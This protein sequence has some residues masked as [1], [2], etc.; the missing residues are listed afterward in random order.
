[1]LQISW[2]QLLQWLQRRNKTTL[3]SLAPAGRPY[4]SNKTGILLGCFHP[5]VL[6]AGQGLVFFCYATAGPL[7]AAGRA[8]LPFRVL[9]SHFSS[10]LLSSLP[11]Q[12]APKLLPL[13]RRS[14]SPAASHWL[15]P[16][17][18]G[19]SWEL[20]SRS[21]HLIQTKHLQ[22]NAS[23][24]RKPG[25]RNRVG[26]LGH[27]LANFSLVFCPNRY[28]V[29]RRSRATQ[30]RK[31]GREIQLWAVGILPLDVGEAVSHLCYK[32]GQAA[33]QTQS[34]Q[35][36][37]GTFHTPT[38]N[39]MCLIFHPS[40]PLFFTGWTSHTDTGGILVTSADHQTLPLYSSFI[41]SRNT[42]YKR[43]KASNNY[44]TY[45]KYVNNNPV[46]LNTF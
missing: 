6:P 29:T 41:K 14:C 32:S 17:L 45:P 36:K 3:P 27:M 15:G 46:P 30:S 31:T 21:S 25:L 11:A 26:V 39:G 7:P 28:L 20:V 23:E 24:S 37:L 13:H 10:S 44:K 18:P 42:P 8:C 16:L 5:S 43:V 1:M 38:F 22:G 40:S 9:R 19:G 34:P 2:A 12:P 35:P 4:K 33:T